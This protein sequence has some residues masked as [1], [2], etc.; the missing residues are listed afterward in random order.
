MQRLHLLISGSVT[1]VG[2]RYFV[3]GNARKLGVAGW[4]KNT[5]ENKVEAVLEGGEQALK[6]M[7]ELCQEG[8]AGS[9]VKEVKILEKKKIEKG[10]EEFQIIL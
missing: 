8:P 7:L 5:N 4:V 1:G 9:W 2:F 3:A 6:K 10:R